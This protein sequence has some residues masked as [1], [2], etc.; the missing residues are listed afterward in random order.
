MK[1]FFLLVTIVVVLV[2]GVI[3]AFKQNAVKLNEFEPTSGRWNTYRPDQRKAAL[4]ENYNKLIGLGYLEGYNAASDSQGITVFKKDIAQP[5]LNFFVSGHAPEAFLMDMEGKILHTWRYHN[6]GDI[7]KN[8]SRNALCTDFWRRAY[9]YKNGDILAIYEGLGLVKLDKNSKLLWSYTSD[10]APHH[11]MEVL[12]NGVI[13]ILTREKKQLPN[14]SNQPV[15]DEFITV[16]SSEGKLV[17]EVSLVKLIENSPYA[18]MLQND[19][20]KAGGI[21]GHILH[22][23]TIE[24][25]DGRL[26]HLSPL[27]KKGN[28]LISILIT[29]TICIID[30]EHQQVV[31]ALGSGMWKHQHQPTFLKNGNI[32]IFNNQ[33]SNTSSSVEEFEPFSQKI[34]WKY[35]GTPMHPFSSN[36]CGSNQRLPNGNTL[37]TESDNGRAFE[38]TPNETIVWEYINAFRAGAKKELIATLFEMV[39]IKPE[40]YPFIITDKNYHLSLRGVDALQQR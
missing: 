11:D 16:L 35:K 39:R 22:T 36:S 27:F 37:I 34:V 19:F 4:N 25:F 5:G 18:S 38:V 3:Y 29:S 1:K 13:Y 17:K 9:L 26:S 8:I 20:I 14:I 7:W 32:L 33:E 23:N 28:I 30:W 24:V 15:F 40:E 10:R 6:A 31:W 12:D 21:M 2:L